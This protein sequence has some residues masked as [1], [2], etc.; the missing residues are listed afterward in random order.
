M[1]TATEIKK[2]E[3]NHGARVRDK[4]N[5]FIVRRKFK[6]WLGALSV[7][8][9]TVLMYLPPKQIKK[10][11]THY[12]INHLI[13]ILEYFLCVAGAVPIIQTEHEM[14]VVIP[15]HAPREATTEE[16]HING[17]IKFHIHNLFQL[18]SSEDVR[19]VMQTELDHFQPD[20]ILVRRAF[21]EYPA[22]SKKEEPPK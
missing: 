13:Y 11:V 7:V 18:L 6:K 17:M 20:Y 19:R 22:P 4:D 14:I 3:E 10:I 21:D 15:E 16:S 2:L 8:A 1:L 5:D 12:E 9:I